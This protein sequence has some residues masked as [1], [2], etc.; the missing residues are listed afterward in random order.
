MSQDNIFTGLVTGDWHLDR[1]NRLDDMANC[2]DF[3]IQ[4]AI[5]RKVNTFV[6]LGDGYKTWHPAPIEMSVMHR[7]IRLVQTK[8]QNPIPT[9]VVVG[10]HDWPESGEHKGVHCFTELKSLRSGVSV[11]DE[12]GAIV[13][14]GW[15]G[16]GI[17]LLFIPHIP[18]AKLQEEQKS[19]A[20]VYENIL[21]NLLMNDAVKQCKTRILFSHVYVKEA[22]VGPCDLVLDGEKQIPLRILKRK[23][24]HAAFLGDIHK[25]Q[26][27]SDSPLILYPG[28]LDR[29][30]FGEAND[31][32]GITIFRVPAPGQVEVEFVPTPARRFVDMVIDA[33]GSGSNGKTFDAPAEGED[34]QAWVEKKIQ[35]YDLD[36]AFVK[37]TFRGTEQQKA[38]VDEDKIRDR[39]MARGA[40]GIRSMSYD[41]AQVRVARAPGL[42]EDLSA[43]KALEKWVGMQNYTGGVADVV[44]SS[45]KK[46]I[47][48]E[49]C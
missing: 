4:T 42:T 35:E 17:A 1:F 39:V 46:I 9:Y 21:D 7:I 27:L 23:D 13:I 3:A 38:A 36:G 44:L 2:V 45:G 34:V 20:E 29:V 8:D 47:G 11:A 40:A 37:I 16:V 5:D 28:S 19:L 22:R 24:L 18:K 30:D 48:T 25:V 33:V 26:K 41:M 12:P 14:A 49:S 32:K 15:S 10:N 31:P 43:P 6:H